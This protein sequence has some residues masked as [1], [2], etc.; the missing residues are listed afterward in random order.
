MSPEAISNALRDYLDGYFQSFD[1]Y[2]VCTRHIYSRNDA[3]ALWSDFLKVADDLSYSAGEMVS[4]PERFLN[5]GSFSGDE[6]ARRKQQAATR[7]VEHIIE[8]FPA[9]AGTS[10]TKSDPT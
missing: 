1:Y 8:Q 6:L 9:T 5:L 7:S 2:P 4:S 10:A 3:Y